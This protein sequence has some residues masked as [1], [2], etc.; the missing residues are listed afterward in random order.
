MNSIIKFKGYR[1]GELVDVVYNRL[2][3]RLTVNGIDVD[4]PDNLNKHKNE[5]LFIRLLLGTQCNLNC[6]YCSQY[7]TDIEYSIEDCD[8]FVIPD[9]TSTIEFWG[10]EPLIYKKYIDRILP[11]IQNIKKSIIT[12]GTLI[13][14]KIVNWFNDNNI[15][16]T[17][18]HDGPSLQR[19]S[20]NLDVELL[21][22]INDLTI[23]TVISPNTKVFETIEYFRNCG[24][25]CK[26]RF[27]PQILNSNKYYHYTEQE[28]LNTAS[29]LFTAAQNFDIIGLRWDT[30]NAIR[31][32]YDHHYDCSIEN[33]NVR[34]FD[35][36]NN[37]F[38]C[39]NYVSSKYII[40]SYKQNVAKVVPTQDCCNNCLVSN[41]CGGGCRVIEGQ[42]FYNT[43]RSYFVYWLA[44]FS[45]AVYNLTEVIL[46][47]AEVL[48]IPYWNVN[49]MI[50][51][52][53]YNYQMPFLIESWLDQK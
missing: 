13:N 5:G 14:Q 15:A 49:K 39:Q 31:G 41:I 4:K 1:R 8:K 47:K 34:V 28:Q 30:M 3:K 9:N 43:C 18:S 11:R 29:E 37:E 12:N 51:K 22:Q 48:Y 2:E 50:Y 21:Q 23:S 38:L 45:S 6:Q 32:I 46:D 10:G 20:C 24:L 27:H 19:P 26:F 17:I 7:K 53:I 40:N 25:K 52:P 42:Q 33:P 36:K 35:I 16:V 44:M